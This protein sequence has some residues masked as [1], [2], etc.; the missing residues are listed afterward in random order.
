MDRGIGSWVTRRA[1]LSGDRTALTAGTRRLS[2]TDLDRRTDQL[3]RS[4]RD[5]GVRKGD[6]VAGLLVNGP[7]F[8]ETMLATAK[9][10]AVFVPMNLRLAPPEVTY[11][12]ADSGADVFVYTALLAPVARAA[13]SGEGV[14]VRTRIVVDGKPADGEADFEQVLGS[15]EPRA[16]GTDVAGSDLSC[17]MYTSGTTGRPKGAMLTHDNHLW[18]VI[19][20]LTY[21]RGLRETDR[22]VT[23]APMFHIGGLGVHT[24]PLL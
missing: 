1:F 20:V 6:R 9:L 12:L 3:A 2:Y 21:G 24:L 22:T 8:V 5:L 10:G 4:L 17:L 14:R 7:A 13:L 15:G 11:L 18:N 19:N 16:L 23:V